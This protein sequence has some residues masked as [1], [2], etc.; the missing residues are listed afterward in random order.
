MKNKIHKYDFL[1][2]GAGLIGTIAA[3]ALNKKKFRVL[4]IDKK[5]NVPKDNRTLAVNAN[6]IDFLKKLGI[7]NGLKS[8]PQ[9]IEK[10]IIKDNVSKQPLIFKN[11][12]EDMGNVIF[13]R[14]LFV[15]SR[16]KLTNLKILKTNTDFEI[17]DLLPE[18]IIQANKKNYQFKKIII[19]IGKNIITNTD[20]KNII[21]DQKHSSYVGFFRHN[22]DHDNTA[23]EF[24]T[25]NGPLA[26]LPSPDVNK[27]RSTF[28]YS[29]KDSINK[30]QIQKLI[31][32][33]ISETHGNLIFDQ[34]ISKFPIT[35]HL[36][37][38]NEKFIYIGDSLKSIHPVAGQGWNLGVKD[39][40]TLCKLLD[41]YSL[42]EKNFNSIYYSR[43]I[44]ESTIYL[45]FTS[46]LNFLYENNISLNK[47]I[48]K[49]GYMALKNFK[50]LRDIFIKQ[51]MGRINLTD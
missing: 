40:Q 51:A 45:S 9:P 13:N 25:D 37:K 43:R 22:K 48:I 38:K 50:S 10:I 31:K 24:F 8:N 7:W 26:V 15:L 49:L 32:S 39:I 18:K 1:I 2:V 28:I 16:K 23:Y 17:K 6:S 35:P 14:E 46:I 11:E 27:K 44:F 41:Q 21:F 20:H 34:S 42:E 12:D 47:R 30:K 19:S 36:T 4:V 33:K 3:L 5:I 29:S